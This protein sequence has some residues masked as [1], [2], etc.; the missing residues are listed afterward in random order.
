M[1]KSFRYV[2]M[3]YHVSFIRKVCV[4][5]VM[6]KTVVFSKHVSADVFKKKIIEFIHVYIIRS[7]HCIHLKKSVDKKINRIEKKTFINVVCI[8][9]FL[10]IKVWCL[11]D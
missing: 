5:V 1:K 7:L 11:N 8:V 9:S 6:V 4:Q 2:K 3:N 10:L